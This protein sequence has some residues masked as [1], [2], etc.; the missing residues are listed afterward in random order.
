MAQLGNF[1]AEEVDTTSPVGSS[2]PLPAGDYVMAIAS[3]KG[4][5]SGPNSKSPGRP[6]LEFEFEVLDGDYKGRRFW[7]LTMWR[8]GP[9]GPEPDPEIPSGKR[10]IAEIAHA[11]G[12]LRLSS[13]EELHGVPIM[14]RLKTKTDSY[15]TKNEWVSCRP[16]NSAPV[17]PLAAAAAAS[18]G[19]KKGPWA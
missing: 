16:A 4:R 6:M 14:V 8:E 13:T 1:N 10:R 5:E 3:E 18:G 17:A 15:G 12:K 9:N 11:A 7:M 19:A 2:D